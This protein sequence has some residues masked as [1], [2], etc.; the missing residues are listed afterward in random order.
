MEH[1]YRYIYEKRCEEK[2]EVRCC[3]LKFITC[4]YICMRVTRARTPTQTHAH[5]DGDLRNDREHKGVHR[6]NAEV[7][8]ALHTHSHTHK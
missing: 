4:R 8:H 1:I 6:E 2:C 3:Q 7:A 5:V